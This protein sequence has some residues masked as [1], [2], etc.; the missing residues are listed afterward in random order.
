[1]ESLDT[2]TSR[3]QEAC[4]SACEECLQ[5][6]AD[7]PAARRAGVVDATGRVRLLRG[8]HARYC[9]RGLDGLSRYMSALDASRPWLAYWILHSL[10]LLD[11]T[12]S[13]PPTGRFS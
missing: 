1:M 6:A 10:A 11:G 7:S 12:C 9:R 3:V 5:A 4:A 8:L 2:H 13:P